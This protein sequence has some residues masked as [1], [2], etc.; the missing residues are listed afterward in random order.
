MDVSVL[1]VFRYF[2]SFELVGVLN[3]FR[4]FTS[5]ELVGGET[6]SDQHLDRD[7]KFAKC[8]SQQEAGNYEFT[9]DRIATLEK[10]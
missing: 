1:N 2:T 7:D 4:Y 10:M 6:G 8:T 9:V 3:V 5:F